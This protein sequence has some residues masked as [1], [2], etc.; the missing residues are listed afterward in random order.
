MASLIENLI[1][2]LEQE[3]EIYKTLIPI[4]E[5]KTKT[6]INNDLG[7]L[8]EI[9]SK[10]QESLD[11]ILNLEKKRAEVII[12]IGTVMSHNPGSLSLKKIIDILDKQPE[13]QQRLSK[14]HKELREQIQRLL[15]INGQ[16][17]TLI[18][19]S[20]EMI[21]FNM[22]FIR[23]TRTLPGNGYNKGAAAT[24]MPSLQTGMF[25]AKQ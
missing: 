10:E 16:N 9:T 8:Q 18:E 13:E 25:D 23:S 11:C 17:K 14:L 7:A 1:S 21:D 12:N 24:D 22:N 4:A 15:D 5:E 3:N 2:A 6:I 20:L 19:Q